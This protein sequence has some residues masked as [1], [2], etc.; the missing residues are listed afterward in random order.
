MKRISSWVTALVLMALTPA[1]QSAEGP[2]AR[3]CHE[4]E[5]SYP[6]IFKDRPGLTTSLLKLAEK[7]LGGKLEVVALPWKRCLEAVK[8]GTLDGIVKI[9]YAPERAQDYVYPMAGD[10]PDAGKRLLIDSYSLYRI[11]GSAVSW[12]GKVLKADGSIGAQSGFSVV[13][14]LIALGVKVDD[15]TRSADGNLRKLVDGRVVAVALQT[16]EGDMSLV[17]MPDIAAKV[18]RVTHFLVEKP[19]FVVFSK[20]YFAKDPVNAK[21]I[22]EAIATAR[23]SAEYKDLVKKFK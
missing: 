5:D 15:G 18:E 16:E 20:A 23:E 8:A 13:K 9:S 19:Y 3:I 17:A 4:G 6:W 7:P 21:K 1:A 2:V 11:K 10:K 12:D 14:Q 22:W